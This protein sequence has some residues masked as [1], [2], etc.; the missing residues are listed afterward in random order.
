L[1]CHGNALLFSVIENY[2][3][4]NNTNGWNIYV[5]VTIMAIEN[6]LHYYV[7]S[8]MTALF[9]VSFEVVM[10][11]TMKTADSWYAT[12]LARLI[13]TEAASDHSAFIMCLSS[14]HNI[15]PRRLTLNNSSRQK[16]KLQQIVNLHLFGLSWSRRGFIVSLFTHSLV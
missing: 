9:R 5:S 13:N 15:G 8:T 14:A 10:I 16:Q 6:M 2:M 4:V 7:I 1:R 3:L 11:M 12:N